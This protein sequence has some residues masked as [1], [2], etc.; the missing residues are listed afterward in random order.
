MNKVA[1][2]MAK[3]TEIMQQVGALMKIPEMQANMASLA[4]EMEKAGLVDEIMSDGLDSLNVSRLAAV[5]ST[6]VLS[7]CTHP[8]A[9]HA[10]DRSDSL[11]RGTACLSIAILGGW[12]RGSSR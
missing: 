12:H 6:A 9:L 8:Q 4:R 3:S 5:G 1:G 10:L 7:C 2:A 11:L